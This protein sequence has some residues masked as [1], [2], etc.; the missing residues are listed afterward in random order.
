M[1]TDDRHRSVN[2]NDHCLLCVAAL[3][4]SYACA[5][6]D[7][8]TRIVVNDDAPSIIVTHSPTCVWWRA[9]R[10]HHYT[11]EESA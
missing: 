8:Q 6:C 2:F 5:D 10:H 4:E 9:T 1:R 11:E 3:R 7:S